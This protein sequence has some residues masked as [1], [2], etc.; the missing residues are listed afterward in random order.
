MKIE[1]HEDSM[2]KDE[3]D[4]PRMPER[5][6]CM[7]NWLLVVRSTVCPNQKRQS[8]RVTRKPAAAGL[9]PQKLYNAAPLRSEASAVGRGLLYQIT[10]SKSMSQIYAFRPPSFPI[11]Q[12]ACMCGTITA[13]GPVH[14]LSRQPKRKRMR[15]GCRKT[16]VKA[17]HNHANIVPLVG[18]TPIHFRKTHIPRC[19]Q[20]QVRPVGK[21]CAS[22]IVCGDVYLVSNR[23]PNS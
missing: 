23:V 1:L 20:D 10:V 4:L 15:M 18:G 7:E 21:V 13:G 17:N 22:P 6:P 9:L 14:I 8:Q 11:T 3:M 5:T 2:I 16:S 19:W 12:P